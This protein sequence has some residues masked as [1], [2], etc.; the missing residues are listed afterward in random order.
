M[1][2]RT[3]LAGI[4]GSLSALAGC[5]GLGEDARGRTGTREPFSVPTTPDGSAETEDE[6]DSLRTR[7]VST[8]G[9]A[10][11]QLA[12]AG[13]EAAAD[14][15]G[16]SVGFVADGTPANPP[17][18]RVTATN[19]G[20]TATTVEFDGVAPFG[21]HVGTY[22]APTTGPAAPAGG[23]GN[24]D[25]AGS[26]GPRLLLVPT[27]DRRFDVAWSWASAQCWR[28]PSAFD[29][30]EVTESVELAPGETTDRVYD[31]VTPKDAECLVPGVYR[32]RDD[33]VDATFVVSVW[34]PHQPPPS[35][36]GDV[37]VPELPGCA[38]RWFHETDGEVFLEPSAEAATTPVP[39]RY[40]LYDLGDQRVVPT[41][42]RVFRLVDGG[43]VPLLP[44]PRSDPPTA[45]FPGQTETRTLRVGGDPR[46]IVDRTALPG[47]RSGRYAVSFG[48]SRDLETV[49]CLAAL[50][51]VTAGS[52]VSLSPSPFVGPP[53]RGTESGTLV[54]EAAPPGRDSIPEADR[55]TVELS[56]AP[57]R[58]PQTTLVLEQVFQRQALRDT[59][60]FIH[61]K[62]TAS[63][64]P[65]DRV[66]L[67]TTTGAVAQ[68][69]G[70]SA[71]SLA[72]AYDGVTY[73]F[74]RRA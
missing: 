55:E 61:E 14:S 13:V 22:E 74:V 21:A 39:I 46:A 72:V 47:L 53:A 25:E 42:T 52:P 49:T 18:V 23:G 54:V 60:A 56:R 28:F 71:Q 45:L 33:S 48:A 3:L 19:V 10:P 27:N 62:Q 15:L 17:R 41:A 65:L 58:D 31:I 9:D 69:L 68:V 50:L 40:T 43:W 26:D 30:P 4:T 51:D 6:V 64:E 5:N 1:R 57:G 11:V 29:P 36:F 2:R 24:G 16:Y 37:T 63:D 38:T 8:L 44:P 66:R 59:L 70:E 7:A 35:R 20:E 67:T 32:F 34:D 12:V 73:E